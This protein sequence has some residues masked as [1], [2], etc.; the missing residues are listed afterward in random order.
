MRDHLR[1]LCPFLS[2]EQLSMFETYHAMLKDWN[3]RMNLTAITEAKEVAEKHFADSLLPMA[4]IG[5][6]ARI[7][8]V[9]T[10]AGFPGVPLL[11]ARPDLKLTLLDSLN[12]RLTFLD[13]VLQEL[14]LSAKL[15]HARA[16]DGG[17]MD[18]LRGGFDLA[19]T[20]AVAHAS[21]ALEWTVPFLKVGGTS[22]LY[23]GARAE[24]ELK[25]AAN[26]L[27]VLSCTARIETFPAPWGERYVIAAKK[28]QKTAK[29]Y[30]RKAGTASKKPL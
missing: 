3:T 8:D 15:V 30:P 6:N 20:R 21:V 7:I 10:G 2:E 23:K 18:A 26:A 5:E 12:K 13:A 9:G 16:E 27:K 24:E 25:E 17:R 1:S 22:L 29:E 28:E 4:L 19:L 14:G 11:I